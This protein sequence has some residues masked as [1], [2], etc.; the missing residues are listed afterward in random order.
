MRKTRT[1]GTKPRYG[2]VVGTCQAA[3]ALTHSS[4]SELDTRV[5]HAWC[6]HPAGVLVQS[7]TLRSEVRA[8][9][10]VVHRCAVI[11]ASKTKS[12]LDSLFADAVGSAVIMAEVL[13]A[14]AEPPSDVPTAD[15]DKTFDPHQL[16]YLLL[17]LRLA[18]A[19]E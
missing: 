17:A 13:H 10:Q 7:L 5:L 18:L 15:A 2:I 14:C 1:L 8:Q 9:L 11:A 6:G 16:Q 4:C 19:G 3:L 12:K